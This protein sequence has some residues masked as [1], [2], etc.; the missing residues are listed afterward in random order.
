VYAGGGLLG[1]AVDLTQQ[2]RIVLMDQCGEV[3]VRER[4]G[5]AIKGC[6]QG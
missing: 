5:R 1:D 6:R 3:A 2:L 4:D